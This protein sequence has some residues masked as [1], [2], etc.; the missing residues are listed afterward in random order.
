MFD[1]STLGERDVRRYNSSTVK[2]PSWRLSRIL[3]KLVATVDA[4]EGFVA[5]VNGSSTVGSSTVDRGE[6]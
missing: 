6:A 2:K 3:P 4:G 1:G 5:I